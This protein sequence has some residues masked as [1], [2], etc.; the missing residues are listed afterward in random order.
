MKNKVEIDGKWYELVPMEEERT[1]D[2]TNTFYYGCDSECGIFQFHVLMDEGGNVWEGTE[3]ITYYPE[4]LNNKEIC[5]YWD[6]SNFLN[7]ILDRPSTSD[8]VEVKCQIEINLGEFED[9][10]YLLQ[11]VRDKGWLS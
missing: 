10:V 3:S 6:N 8:V 1:R 11:Q 5:E 9:L 7:A 4:G 2:V